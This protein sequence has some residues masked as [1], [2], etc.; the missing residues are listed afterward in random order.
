MTFIAVMV[1]GVAEQLPGFRAAGAVVHLRVCGVPISEGESRSMKTNEFE[2]E[3]VSWQ[4]LG[5]KQVRSCLVQRLPNQCAISYSTWALRC[6]RRP[7]ALQFVEAAL[8]P[9]KTRLLPLTRLLP[10]A[11]HR[12]CSPACSASPRAQ[13]SRSTSRPTR[14][15]ST[16]V[17]ISSS[18]GSS[19]S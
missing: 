18:T 3:Q 13:W 16:C 14:R 4:R 10:C 19:R 8:E 2:Q 5:E 15:T 11:V 17:H 6:T 1:Q 12:S 7:R 9:S